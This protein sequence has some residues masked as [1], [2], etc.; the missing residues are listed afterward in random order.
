MSEYFLKNW[1]IINKSAIGPF[2]HKHLVSVDV[3]IAC[4]LGFFFVFL[5]G[6]S[7]SQRLLQHL[8]AFSIKCFCGCKRHRELMDAL[9]RV[10]RRSESTN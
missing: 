9:E 3:Q 2:F 4:F 8:D 7:L 10:A 1:F 6:P 5:D